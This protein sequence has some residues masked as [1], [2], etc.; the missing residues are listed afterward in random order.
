MPSF[1]QMSDFLTKRCQI[2]ETLDFVSNDKLKSGAQPLKSNKTNLHVNKS[3]TTKSFLNTQSSIVCPLCNGN[4]Y[5]QQCQ[6]FKKL[7]HQDKIEFVKRKGMCFNCLRK[8]HQIS[9]CKYSHCTICNKKHH[10]FLHI[11]IE[12]NLNSDEK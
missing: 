7:E 1:K 12:S 2:L 9:A 4:H 5:I 3:N 10:T 6:K 11:N 8:N